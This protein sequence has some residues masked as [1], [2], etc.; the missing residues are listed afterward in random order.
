[1]K[2]LLQIVQQFCLTTGVTKPVSVVGNPDAQIVQMLALLNEGLD[3]LVSKYKWPQL[4]YE[5][6]FLSTAAENQGDLETLA[7]GFVSLIPGTMWSVSK[8]L[9]TNGSITPQDT[10]VLKIWGRPSA[11]IN[12]RQVNG[13]LH[14][15]PA[16]EANLQY[17]FEYNS[18]YCVKDVNGVPKQY[19]TAD[20]DTTVLPDLLYTMDLRWRW[21]HEKGLAYAENFRMFEM[22]CKQAFVDGASMKNLSM[23]TREG[24]PMPG[25][26]V[27]VG[28]WQQ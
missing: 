8:R 17:R 18:Q 19:F 4:Q 3:E 14:F 11:F 23:D 25:V 1:M 20:T 7:P 6:T 13:Q 24:N 22:R 5:A 28:S 12:F 15:I 27:P 16:G 2:T 26:V 21:K 9:P 10:Q